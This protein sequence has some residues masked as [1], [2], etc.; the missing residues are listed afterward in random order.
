MVFVWD[1]STISYHIRALTSCSNLTTL[2]IWDIPVSQ[3]ALAAVSN[4]TPN[5]QILSLY[6]LSTPA[7]AML[8]NRETCARLQELNL[9]G[10]AWLADDSLM[11]LIECGKLRNLNISH[12][13]GAAGSGLS[14]KAMCQLVKTLGGTLET[15]QLNSC[16]AVDDS[17]GLAVS[18]H[19]TRLE[20][21]SLYDGDVTDKS[22]CV[23]VSKLGALRHLR[24]ALTG[25][26]CDTLRALSNAPCATQLLSLDISQLYNVT[27][28]GI[29]DFLGVASALE[30]LNMAGNDEVDDDTI[31]LLCNSCTG[32]TQLDISG[33]DEITDAGLSQLISE[34]DALTLVN[35]TNC[36]AISTRLKLY[37]EERLHSSIKIRF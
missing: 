33:C 6:E 23:V 30:T 3:Q 16:G 9:V 4:V 11:G 1:Y 32:L 10:L 25:I 2:E 20:H 5:L 14:S 22:M 31:M 36:K 18:A 27:K 35:V 21:L 8:T 13:G 7:K 34:C 17:V 15:L 24:L 12:C 29:E 26:S 37:L 19:C 28:D